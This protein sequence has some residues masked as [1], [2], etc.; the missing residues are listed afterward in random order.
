[1]EVNRI[2][3]DWSWRAVPASGWGLFEHVTHFVRMITSILKTSL[4]TL[5]NSRK[6]RV[7]QFKATGYPTQEHYGVEVCKCLHGTDIDICWHNYTNEK[8]KTSEHSY[9]TTLEYN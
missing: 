8:H 9:N 3:F 7:V 2:V 4:C 6:L 1:M 5:L